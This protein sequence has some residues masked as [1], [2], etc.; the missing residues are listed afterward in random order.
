M[1]KMLITLRQIKNQPN[2]CN[3]PAFKNEIVQ[4]F[5]NSSPYIFKYA[6]MTYRYMAAQLSNL[7]LKWE[8]KI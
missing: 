5:N 2:K 8:A 3:D 1:Q 7:I 6:N 4:T